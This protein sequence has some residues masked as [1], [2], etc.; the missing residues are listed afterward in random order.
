MTPDQICA[1]VVTY[2][3]SPR[4][5]PLIRSLEGQVRQIVVVDN[6]SD[7]GGAEVLR[8][9]ASMAA[10]EV[11]HNS[12]NLGVAAALNQGVRWAAE[13]GF[14]WVLTLDQDSRPAENMLA[15]LMAARKS[16]EEPERTAILAPQVI[17]EGLGRKA[18]FLQ[19]RG[20]I[21]YRR[22]TCDAPLLEN[23]TTVITSGS[24]IQISAFE[25]IGGF[26]EDFFIDYV[27]TEF[28]LRAQTHGYRVAAA[29]RAK[30]YHRLG[31]RKRLAFGPFSL[32]PTFHP[33]SRWYTISRNR[34]PMLRA[35]GLRFPHWLT[36]E[37]V[38]SAFITL[39]MLLT[40]DERPAKLNAIL[41]GSWDG[42]R[43][44]LGPPPVE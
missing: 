41:R 35:Y 28:C 21:F 19:P 39:R 17:D 8:Q 25:V 26:R 12:R 44:R 11:I 2:R 37:L 22:T 42:L 40:E 23:V 4:F 30:L 27:D 7:G 15:E 33:P 1:V 24:L 10:V 16:L 32:F 5:V 34:V 29:C 13:L 18:P 14:A 43:G 20:G 6:A 3:P 38:A 9:V 31:E 36:Y